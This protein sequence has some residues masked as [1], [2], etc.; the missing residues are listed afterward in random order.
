VQD[1]PKAITNAREDNKVMQMICESDLT[2][3]KKVS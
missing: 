1:G 3:L 2:G